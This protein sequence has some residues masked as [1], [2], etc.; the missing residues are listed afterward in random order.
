LNPNSSKDTEIKIKGLL[1]IQVSDYHQD[2]LPSQQEEAEEVLVLAKAAV[3]LQ[4]QKVQDIEDVIAMH[5]SD[6]DKEDRAS[7]TDYL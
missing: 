6:L 7:M 4:K 1:D 3:V 5:S 2:D